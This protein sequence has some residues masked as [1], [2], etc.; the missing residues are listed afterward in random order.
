MQEK[1]FLIVDTSG[2]EAIVLAKKNEQLCSRV[3]NSGR[4]LTGSLLLH[5]TSV[6]QEA[7]ISPASI[8]RIL[9]CMGPG[10]YTSLRITS[11]TL[12]PFGY[13]NKT[14]LYPLFV[15]DLEVVA[16]ASQVDK[17]I[18][19]LH[20]SITLTSKFGDPS[21]KH[22]EI[23]VKEEK[24]CIQEITINLYETSHEYPCTYHEGTIKLS[25]EV[26]EIKRIDKTEVLTT[27]LSAIVDIESTIQFLGKKSETSL[28]PEYYRAPYITTKKAGSLLKI[29]PA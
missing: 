25:K 18:L 23:V 9:A 22:Y 16:I 17:N 2:E 3:W 12:I 5:I 7:E 13:V 28:L 19:P 1:S 29:E 21:V 24:L 4:D 26:D 11:A 10:S 14:P 6:L 20:C 8:T 15:H 27:C